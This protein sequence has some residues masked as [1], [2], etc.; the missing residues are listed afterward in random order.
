MSDVFVYRKGAL[1]DTIFFI[2]FLFSLKTIYNLIFFAGNYLYRELFKGIEFIKFLDADSKFVFDLLRGKENLSSIE[3]YYIFSN[4][5]DKV[6][7]NYHIYSP[8]SENEWVYS[9]P[10]KC[11]GM[12]VSL[13]DIY[14]PVYFNSLIY[15]EIKNAPFILFHPG[16]GGIKKRWSLE[17]FF[18]VEKYLND[19]GYDVYYLLGESENTILDCFNNKKFFYNCSLTDIIFLLQYASG[20]IGGDSGPGHLAGLIGVKGFLLFGPSNQETYKPYKNLKI[21][22]VSDNLEEIEPVFVIEKWEELI[23]ER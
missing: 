2:P 18:V 4:F 10:F 23:E 17:K 3:N 7:D 14:L 12:E 5:I 9:Y 13:K 8:I 15:N 1:G 21:I 16:S 20:Y 6:R 11:L 19:K 22:R